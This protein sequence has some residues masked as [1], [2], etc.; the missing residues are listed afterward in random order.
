MSKS[1][2]KEVG[3]LPKSEY[4][5]ILT[6]KSTHIPGDERSRTNP[7]HGYPEST[8]RSWS[9]EVFTSEADW[10]KEIEDKTR[11]SDRFQAIHARP[12]TITTETKIES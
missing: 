4:W 7:G 1:Y 11:R 9:I 8:E 5:A 10:K 12:A 2:P 3:E 6:P